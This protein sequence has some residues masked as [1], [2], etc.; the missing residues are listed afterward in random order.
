MTSVEDSPQSEPD[1]DDPKAKVPRFFSQLKKAH[2]GRI[3][4]ELK[5]EDLEESFVRGAGY[6]VSVSYVLLMRIILGIRQRSRWPVREQD[7]EQRTA[8]T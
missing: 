6:S 4:P 3:I 2:K 7:G 5:E 8:A 1:T